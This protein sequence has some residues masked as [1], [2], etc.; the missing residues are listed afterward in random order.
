MP[1]NGDHGSASV[2]VILMLRIRG[3]DRTISLTDLESGNRLIE[4]LA[5]SIRGVLRSKDS[6][7][8]IGDRDL[9]LILPAVLNSAIVQLAANK[10]LSHLHSF[11]KDKASGISGGF[12]G[13]STYPDDGPDAAGAIRNAFTAM[14]LAEQS[15][16]PFVQYLPACRQE[17]TGR[18][19]LEQELFN[20]IIQCQLELYFQPQFCLRR[21]SIVGAEVLLRWNNNPR[22][23]PVSPAVFIPIAEENGFIDDLTDWVADRALNSCAQVQADHPG[24]A[25]SINLSTRTLKRT[26]LKDFVANIVELWRVPAE[27]FVLEITETAMMDDPAQT[28]EILRGLKSLGVRI[29][30]DD[31]GTGYSSLGYLSNLP[32]DEVKIDRCFIRDLVTNDKNRR[33]VK[34]IISLAKNFDM[35]VVAE[36]VEDL[37]SLELLRQ[38]GCDKAQGY[39]IAKPMPENDFRKFLDDREQLMRFRRK[40]AVYSRGKAKNAK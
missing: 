4:E 7:F 23:G 26:D 25:Y 33:I 8:R 31:F 39:L 2:H 18:H 37:E 16:S 24:C 1:Q 10:I 20:S 28:A 34:T 3:F 11:C 17:L 22:V 15:Y 40:A 13:A 5:E 32:I 27:T 30:I 14:L 6:V 35:E 21:D 12:V 9:A 29:S 38:F 19:L 36:G